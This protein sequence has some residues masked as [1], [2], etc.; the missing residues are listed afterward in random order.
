MS[1]TTQYNCALTPVQQ[2]TRQHGIKAAIVD[3]IVRVTKL[4]NG[5]ELEFL[6]SR[7]LDEQLRSFIALEQDCC[8]FL[9]FS[10][11][12]KKRKLNLVIDGPPDAAH[13]ITRFSNALAGE[14]L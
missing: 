5:L 11:L 12:R 2:R 4:D 13:I 1:N 9:S 7:A 6:F 10:L 8:Q 3:Q 14:S